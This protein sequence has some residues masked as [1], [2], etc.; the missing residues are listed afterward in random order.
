MELI[1]EIETNHEKYTN[2]RREIHAYPELAYQEHRTSDFVAKQLQSFGIH[3][4]RGLGKTGVVGTLRSGTG[5]KAI[6]LSAA[7]DALP[8]SERHDVGHQSLVDG[9]RQ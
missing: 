9:V 4:E 2:W 7:M 8:L 5:G 6:G 3:V 1:K